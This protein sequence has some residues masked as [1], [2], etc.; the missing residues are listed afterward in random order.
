MCVA[1]RSQQQV[2]AAAAA[3]ATRTRRLRRAERCSRRR[4]PSCFSCSAHFC[5]QFHIDVAE[6]TVS[7][8]TVSSRQCLAYNTHTHTIVGPVAPLLAPQATLILLERAIASFSFARRL[9]ACN[10]AA[11]I[12]RR[13]WAV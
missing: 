8:K 1:F 7:H 2:A 10:F 5:E 11:A 4:A 9:S 12:A 13:D 3:A 6:E